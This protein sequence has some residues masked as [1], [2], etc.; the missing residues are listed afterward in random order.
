MAVRPTLTGRPLFTCRRTHAFVLLTSLIQCWLVPP[1]FTAE[2]VDLRNGSRTSLYGGGFGQGTTVGDFY[3]WAICFGDVDGDGFPDFL[4]SSANA[5]GP[6][7]EHGPEK[8]VYLI[9]GRPHSEIDSLYAVD[10]PGIADIVFYRG[11]FSIACVDMDA[12]GYDDIVLAENDINIVFGRP[13]AQFLPL[14]NFKAGSPTYTPPD[15]HVVGSTKLGGDV[16]DIPNFAYDSVIRS[17]AVGDLNDDGFGDIAFGNHIACDPP[18]T[19]VNGAAYIIFGRHRGALAPLTN[20]DYGS[21][22]PHPDVVILGDSNEGYPTNLVVGDLDG[23]RVDDLLT[24]TGSGWGEN[25]TTPGIGEIHGWWGKRVWRSSYDTQIDDF[26]FALQGSPGFPGY[27]VGYRI[28][29]GDLD[30]DGR[31]DL[32]LGSAYGYGDVLPP[33]RIGMGE[34]RVIFGRARALWPRWS[35]AVAMTDVLVLGAESSDAISINGPQE[36]GICFSVATGNRDGDKYAD[37]LIGAGIVRRPDDGSR[38]GGAY[39]LSGRPRSE[40]QPFIDLREDYDMVIHGV[41]YT[42]S[43][44]YQFD[45]LGYIT[46]MG[47]FDG[48]GKDEMF[49]AAPFA[50]GPANSIPDC[51][52]IYVIYDSEH[53]PTEIPRRPPLVSRALLDNYPNPFGTSTTFSIRADTDELVSLTVY[54]ATGREVARI[55]QSERMGA[56]RRL[57]EWN[58]NG[59]NGAPLPSG[60]YFAR[61]RAGQE[62]QTRKTIVVR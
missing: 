37:L 32:I 22:D 1:A 56:G 23:D 28:T 48:N 60:V 14:Y 11:G 50:D 29:T 12:D 25:N 39:L 51:G 44:G 43:P 24:S 34:Y 52:E 57:V 4:S 9:F 8:D 47:D 61:L 55:I 62:S 18:G 46:A 6:N 41:D 30:G 16:V 7:D 53:T 26:D 45:R 31:D 17:L 3:G 59:A 40:W 49:I 20:V 54:D 2:S 10:S 27:T 21:A 15:I 42:G 13:R 33:D 19:C 36:W 35:D 38:P 5:D 58:A